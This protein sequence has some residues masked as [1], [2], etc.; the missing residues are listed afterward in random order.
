MTLDQPSLQSDTPGLSV[1]ANRLHHH[2]AWL[3]K[4]WYSF[5]D[6]LMKELTPQEREAWSIAESLDAP[7][8]SWVDLLK[9]K[10][11]PL[12]TLALPSTLAMTA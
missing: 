6:I 1:W 7:F 11:Y 2:P 9:S 8:S 5:E 3:S 10:P 12:S 4:E